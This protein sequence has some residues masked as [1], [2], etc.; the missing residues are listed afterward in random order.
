MLPGLTANAHCFDGLAAAGLDDFVA[1][2]LR[3]RGRSAKP[4]TGYAIEDHARDV[5]D[6]MDELGIERVAVGGHS[7]GALVAVYLG[8]RYPDRVDRL[9]LLDVASGTVGNDAVMELIGPSLRRLGKALPSMDAHLAKM[10][11]APFWR[12]YW[13]EHVEAYMVAD[14]EVR[15]DGTVMPRVRPDVVAQVMAAAVSENWPRLFGGV[16][17]P[18]LLVHAPG[19][20]GPPGTSPIV[21]PEQA[22]VTVD[23]LPN[24]RYVTVP[25]NHITM[26]FGD[27]ATHVAAAITEFL[28][29]TTEIPPP[30]GGG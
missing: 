13:D 12:G 27:P 11:S 22:A 29:T 8:A 25:G 28:A 7:F 14:V 9:A 18:A 10:R 1:V 17:Q 2:D 23:E 21:L 20:F 19:P 6:L 3:G 4:R 26:L 16:W 15:P 5:I 24:S 30:V